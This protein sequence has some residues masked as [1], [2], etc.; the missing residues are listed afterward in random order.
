MNFTDIKMLDQKVILL[1]NATVTVTRATL[2]GTIG[3]EPME[4]EMCYSGELDF[5]HYKFIYNM[6]IYGCTDSN[7]SHYNQLLY[8]GDVQVSNKVAACNHQMII[9]IEKV[10]AVEP[11]FFLR[12]K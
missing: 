8:R 2:K 6:G 11:F 9:C 4:G 5:K 3:T 7:S 12:R 1:E 10:R